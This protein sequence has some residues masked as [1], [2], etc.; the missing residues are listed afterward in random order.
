MKKA[1]ACTFG[2]F[3][4]VGIL[5]MAPQMAFSEDVIK[6]GVTQPLTGPVGASGTYVAQGAK[7]AA[8]FLNERGGILG[9][10][11]ELII[12][13]NKSNPKEAVATAEKLIVRDKVPV[14]MGAW[15]STYTLAVMPKL[16]EYGVPMVVETSSSSKITTSGNPWIFRISPTSE[17]E[18]KAFA[19][20]VNNFHIKKADFLVVNNDWGRGAAD[21]FSEML[22]SKGIQ[23][24]ITET[25]D[26]AAQDMSAQL[27]KIKASGSDTLFVTTGVEQLT[28]VLKQAK[29]QQLS[30]QIITT[31]G[32]QAPDQLIEQAGAAAGG[33]YH[34]LFFAPW[35]PESAPN[36]EVA[37]N[38]V[39]E[40]KK[41]G[42]EFAGLTEGFR[43]YDGIMTIAA[44][45]EAAKSTNPDAIRKALWG[46]KVKGV[47][48]DISFI[49]QGPQGKESGQNI[50]NVYVVTIKNGKVA[51]P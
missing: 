44:G 6:I 4:S 21:E 10:K 32:S 13:D 50:P 39:N 24:G 1:L 11:V 30:Q 49:K 37:K 20:K 28:L 33:S 27:A 48:G 42:Y 36:P 26:A 31:G 46:V 9:K 23:V 22:K 29:E 14:L 18:A 45:I 7:I 15:S 47:N 40:W 25:M 16:M 5:L 17:M 34:L 3:A 2:L 41:R 51:L 38:F 35:F 43:G 19:A 8:S 12:E